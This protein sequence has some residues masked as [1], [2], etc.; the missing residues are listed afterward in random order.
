MCGGK[1]TK[2]NHGIPTTPAFIAWGILVPAIYFSQIILFRAL[3]LWPEKTR[4]GSRGSDIM[5]FETTAGFCVT[6]LAIVGII[7]WF[8]LFPDVLD[9]SEIDSD[10]FYGR[11]RFVEDHMIAP[12]ISYQFFNFLLCW[13]NADLRDPAMIGHHLVTGSLAYFGLH[14]YLHAEGLFFFGFAEITN[15]PLTFVDIFKYF[16]ALKERFS[17]VNEISRVIFAL[18]FIIIRLIIW[19]YI[20]FQFNVKSYHLIASGKAHSN[21]VVGFFMFANLFLT[22]LQFFWGSK[23]FGFLFKSNK[24][25]KKSTKDGSDK[26]N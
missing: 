5:A 21:F 7:G 3:N 20:S 24:D 26:S 1:Q 23:I 10:Y 13:V 6:Y 9:F 17:L 15:V 14:P 22:F 18:L 2:M 12:M 25:K 11:S 19:P 16:P 4:K 8:R